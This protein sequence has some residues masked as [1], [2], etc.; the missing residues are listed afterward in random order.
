M[1][2]ILKVLVVLLLLVLSSSMIMA[3]NSPKNP[4]PCP[5]KNCTVFL[6]MDGILN[7][8]GTAA[9]DAWATQV[10]SIGATYFGAHITAGT[11]LNQ[12]PGSVPLNS[13]LVV[14]D[15]VFNH[16][17]INLTKLDSVITGPGDLVQSIGQINLLKNHLVRPHRSRF[18]GPTQRHPSVFEPG[19]QSG[20]SGA[21]ARDAL[22]GPRLPGD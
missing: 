22:H 7:G 13:G 21:L 10:Q 9:A 17:G 3:Q 1:K 14:F 11:P 2:A 4:T 15:T 6:W 8:T 18:R 20:S 16:G 5:A 19:I 12:T